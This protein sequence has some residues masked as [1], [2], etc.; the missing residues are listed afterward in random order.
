MLLFVSLGFPLLSLMT[1]I[2]HIKYD[3]QSMQ[4]QSI[5]SKRVIKYSNIKEIF[6]S[7]D[8]FVGCSIVI[9]ME[10]AFQPRCNSSASY[11]KKCKAMRIIDTINMT[12]MTF[13]DLKKIL[14]YYRGSV[15]T[16]IENTKPE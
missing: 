4:L 2:D 6:Y 9:N 13:K 10:V 5:K 8:S 16:N 15:V 12:G 3:D 11:L 7:K 1:L 14:S